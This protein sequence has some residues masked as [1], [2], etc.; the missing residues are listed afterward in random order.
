MSADALW[1][2]LIV[3]AVGLMAIYALWD[4]IKPLFAVK[5]K[6][7]TSSGT[8]PA[9][10]LPRSTAWLTVDAVL[11]TF[12][13]WIQIPIHLF[14]TGWWYVMAESAVFFLS[15]C[16]LVVM[17]L[18][19][20]QSANAFDR[21]EQ[22]FVTFV[23]RYRNRLFLRKKGEKYLDLVGHMLPDRTFKG[24]LDPALNREQNEFWR[25]V[26]CN[27]AEA[28]VGSEVHKL[29]TVRLLLWYIN[30]WYDVA[31]IGVRGLVEVN[32]RPIE[33]WRIESRVGKDSETGADTTMPKVHIIPPRRG[34]TTNHIRTAPERWVVYV[35][36]GEVKGAY[37]P[38]DTIVIFYIRSINPMQQER[39][40][41]IWSQFLNDAAV[42]I[43]LRAQRGLTM[44]Q[45]FD[46]NIDTKGTV[47]AEANDLLVQEIRRIKRRLEEN[48]G[49]TI[50]DA[51][52]PDEAD[53]S[54]GVQIR[55][56]TIHTRSQ[57]EAEALS[58][59]WVAERQ[60]K[61]KETLGKAEAVAE[62]AVTDAV[63]QAIK[64]HGEAG[65][66]ARET[67]AVAHAAGEAKNATLMA[68]FGRSGAAQPAEDATSTLLKQLVA[69]LQQQGKTQEEIREALT[70]ARKEKEE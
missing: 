69:L 66:I 42:D 9:P 49:I 58:A 31:L 52:Q 62:A 8:A 36:Q 23:K 14:L 1:G 10:F 56:L 53:Y 30:I 21:G 38:V 6:K 45:I 11:L 57:K 35:E 28:P 34:E 24:L 60:G 7:A 16:L 18:Y 17:P 50:D 44:A 65:V 68:S 4:F 39:Y 43:V 33:K 15:G 48:I 63:A 27:G 2:L 13:I 26:E 51:A 61:A 54:G 41:G 46:L 40:Q 29:L 70:Q 25:I 47:G 20:V 37:I 55:A 22:T 12:P 59:P 32:E 5:K 19:A 67:D 64:E 3:V